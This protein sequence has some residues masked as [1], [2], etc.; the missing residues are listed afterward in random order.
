MSSLSSKLPI[1]FEISVAKHQIQDSI[2]PAVKLEMTHLS[3]DDRTIISDHMSLT[4]IIP[5]PP[6]VFATF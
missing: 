5:L 2:E 1:S 4:L 6:S 3:Q